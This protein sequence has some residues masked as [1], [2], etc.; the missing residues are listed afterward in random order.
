MNINF[1]HKNRSLILLL[2]LQASLFAAKA[3]FSGTLGGSLSSGLSPSGSQRNNTPNNNNRTRIY[4][5]PNTTGNATLL[6][7]SISNNRF[8]NPQSGPFSNSGTTVYGDPGGPGSGGGG[9]G[10][11]N[12]VGAPFDGG[13]SVL[14]AFGLGAGYRKTKGLK[15]K[16]QPVA[17]E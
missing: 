14:L 8:N 10:D 7:D 3:Q 12:D 1:F 11:V 4:T 17:K 6:P 15:K 5:D 9:G 16:E 13:L 2:C